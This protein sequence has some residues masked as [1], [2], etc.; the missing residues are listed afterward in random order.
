L[1]HTLRWKRDYRSDAERML[2]E[3]RN[4]Q[5]LNSHLDAWRRYELMMNEMSETG[6]ERPYRLIAQQELKALAKQTVT[7]DFQKA[8]LEDYT[9]KAQELYDRGDKEEAREISRRIVSLYAD[10]PEA[11]DCVKV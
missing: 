3:A 7:G 2:A 5:T 6:D 11:R 8:T 4:M 10:H 1:S 9:T